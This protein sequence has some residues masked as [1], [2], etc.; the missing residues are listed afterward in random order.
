MPEIVSVRRKGRSVD[1]E[2]DDG[3]ALRCDRDFLPAQRLAAGQA[4][5]PPFLDRFRRQAASHDAERTALR[6]LSSRPRSRAEILRR[7]RAKQVSEDVARAA[8]DG[9]AEQGYLDDRAFARSFIDS[10][11]RFRP[12]S[13]AMLRAELR[14]QGVDGGLAEEMT[15]EI[16]DLALAQALVGE[17][18]ARRGRP[19]DEEEQAALRAR[20]G[21]LLQ[22]RGFPYAIAASAI[23]QAETAPDPASPGSMASQR[24]SPT[25]ARVPFS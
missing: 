12:R 24:V 2:F 4:M 11:L 17:Q 21:A 19:Q 18:M 1:V 25:T 15:R 3:S 23:R 20:L 16:D 14:A 8:V 22:R 9:L 5:E 7:L 6:W 10:R 13:R